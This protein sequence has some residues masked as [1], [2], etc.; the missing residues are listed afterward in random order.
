MVAFVR[1][2][3]HRAIFPS[4]L[5]P[6][7]NLRSVVV[8]NINRVSR[9]RTGPH[10][11]PLSYRCRLRYHR[12]RRSARPRVK[13]PIHRHPRQSPNQSHHSPGLEDES[14]TGIHTSLR[15]NEAERLLVHR[16]SSRSPCESATHPVPLQTNRIPLPVSRLPEGDPTA[17][18]G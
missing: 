1:G 10:P 15:V 17:G 3:F 5:N 9:A 4:L 2:F 13:L 12:S 18:S 8:E 6:R 7:N 16:R 14:T 11:L